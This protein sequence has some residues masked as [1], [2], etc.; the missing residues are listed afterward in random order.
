MKDILAASDRDVIER[1]ARS[2]SLLAF[3][4]DGT[5]API[6]ADRE[7][8]RMRGRTRALLL[9]VAQLY[10]CVVIS[11]RSR[12]DVLPRLDGA[13]MV[14]IVGNHGIEPSPDQESVAA[15]N[16]ALRRALALEL[17]GVAG[18]EMEDKRFSLAIHY[19]GSR[20]PIEARR[21]IHEAAARIAIPTRL[22]D[23]K[24]VVNVVAAGAPTKGDA[25]LRLRRKLGVEIGLYIGD[26]DTDEDVFKIEADRDQLVSIRVGMSSTSAARY[27]VRTQRYVD[28]LLARLLRHRRK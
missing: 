28:A 17:Y 9:E 22:I 26:D 15:I 7:A 4:F 20:D 10:P 6:V 12:G 25:V 11:G 8:A 19:R 24:F 5:L 23:G 27:F 18:V 3:D 16:A 1:V 21:V 14:E 13:V 2:Q